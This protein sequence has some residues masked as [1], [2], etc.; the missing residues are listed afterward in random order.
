MIEATADWQ[1]VPYMLYDELRYALG[2]ENVT[3]KVRQ[4]HASTTNPHFLRL[5]SQGHWGMMLL[6]SLLLAFILTYV[7]TFLRSSI[8]IRGQK[9]GRQPPIM[10]YWIPFLGNLLPYVWDPS[11]FC[12]KTT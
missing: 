5:N 11:G 1:H 4:W 3:T 7:T 9:V 10:P 12:T 2:P 6:A 8:A